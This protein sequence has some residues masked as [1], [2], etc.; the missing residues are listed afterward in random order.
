MDN[1]V[2]GI[3]LTSQLNDDLGHLVRTSGDLVRT[4][5]DPIRTFGETVKRLQMKHVEET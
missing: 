4:L 1:Q 3:V 2:H 5:G